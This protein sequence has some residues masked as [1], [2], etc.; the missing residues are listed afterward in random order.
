MCLLRGYKIL[1]LPNSRVGLC[2]FPILL[3]RRGGFFSSRKAAEPQRNCGPL[4]MT[5]RRGGLA[6]CFSKKNHIDTVEKIMCL[7]G[8]K[9][10]ISRVGQVP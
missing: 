7:C 4:G 1:L 5:F 8:Y 2:D 9:I 3:V 6:F 10:L